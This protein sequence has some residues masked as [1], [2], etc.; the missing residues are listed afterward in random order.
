MLRK[1]EID[2]FHHYDNET[3]MMIKMGC[4]HYDNE[5]WMMIKMG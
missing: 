2:D 5:T 1:N 4:H 3:W